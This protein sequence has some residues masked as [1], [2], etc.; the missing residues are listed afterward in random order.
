LRRKIEKLREE[1]G[2]NWLSVLGEREARALQQKQKEDDKDRAGKA[3]PPKEEGRI[4]QAEEEAEPRRQQSEE[5][6]EGLAV[7]NGVKVVKKKGKKK[8]GKGK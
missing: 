7:S 3:E 8:K 6:V 4:V 1:V 5:A 2:E